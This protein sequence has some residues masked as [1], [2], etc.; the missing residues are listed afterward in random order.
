MGNGPTM[1]YY[2]QTIAT[3]QQLI[4]ANDLSKAK[5]MLDE[6]LAMPYIPQVAQSKFLELLKEVHYRLKDNDVPIASMDL[7]NI[8]SYLFSHDIDR[9]DHALTLLERSN[10]R[11]YLPVI[12]RFL[13]D[14]NE[15]ASIKTAL[16]HIL[17]AQQVSATV[18][19]VK[20]GTTVSVDLTTLKPLDQQD[21]AYAQISLWIDQLFADNAALSSLLRQW[22]W[23]LMVSIY[24]ITLT[25]EGDID[26]LMHQLIDVAVTQ[27]D[28]DQTTLLD[29]YA[30]LK[31]H[32]K[33]H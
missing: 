22:A 30:I 2:D 31:N 19:V 9:Q 13:M 5:A 4:N 17:L 28:L 16:L 25:S 15:D 33:I 6:E 23:D 29:G 20:N 27:F 11:A 8:E 3:I 14:P 32:H 26:L 21:S 24:P 12:Q 18:D 1:N 7:D 10:V